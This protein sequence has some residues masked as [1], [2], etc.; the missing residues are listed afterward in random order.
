MQ[1]PQC[2]IECKV[3]RK[4]GKIIHIC[5]NPQCESYKKIVAEK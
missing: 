5:R 2:K 1:C 4:D 3:E